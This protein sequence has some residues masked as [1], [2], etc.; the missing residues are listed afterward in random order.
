MKLLVG[1]ARELE[2]MGMTAGEAGGIMGCW[3]VRIA[4]I[5]IVIAGRLGTGGVGN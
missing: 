1:C 4:G 2:T 5:V 3:C